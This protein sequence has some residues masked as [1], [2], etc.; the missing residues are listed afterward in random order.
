MSKDPE[1]CKEAKKDME[2]CNADL[3]AARKKAVDIGKKIQQGKGGV[4]ERDAKAANDKI[5]ELEQKLFAID[6]KNGKVLLIKK[7]SR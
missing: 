6:K 3:K 4:D 1:K 7:G 2:K 5:K